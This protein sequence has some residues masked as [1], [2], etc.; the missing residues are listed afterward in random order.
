MIKAQHPGYELWQEGIHAKRGVS[1]A[2]CHMPY[3]SQG[4]VKFTD[5]QIQSPLAK[6]NRSCQNCHRQSEQELINNVISSQDK[7]HELKMTAEGILIKAHIEAKA[8]WDNGATK[9]EMAP[10]LMYIRHAQWRWDYA[11]ASHGAAFHAP[12]E[13]LRILGTSIQKGSEARR[14]L[15]TVLA[16]KGVEKVD[17]PD[18]SSKQ[19]A[20]AYLG[21][22]IT[23]MKTAK[24]QF[25]KEVVPKWEEKANQR[26]KS[27]GDK[28]STTPKP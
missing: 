9:D 24:E 2:D 15:A 21:M 23:K 6:I 5:H 16:K 13:V 1:C 7:A 11:T 20:H 18:L 3:V 28:K 12:T 22:D 19:K 10:I 27:W 17:F 14:L 26:Q 8:A 25:L 4:G